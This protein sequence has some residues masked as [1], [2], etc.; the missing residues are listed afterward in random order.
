M[1]RQRNGQPW[2]SGDEWTDGG[3][4]ADCEIVSRFGNER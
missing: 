3:L 1:E 2:Q 4:I